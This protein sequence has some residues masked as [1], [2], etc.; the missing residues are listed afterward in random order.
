MVLSVRF[1]FIS[2]FALLELIGELGG[3]AGGGVLTAALTLTTRVSLKAKVDP[4]LGLITNRSP[5]SLPLCAQFQGARDPGD[6]QASAEPEEEEAH[7]RARG[8][9]TPPVAG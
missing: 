4:A 9:Q 1:S 3:G 6:E 7:L 5:L 2:L 8:Q